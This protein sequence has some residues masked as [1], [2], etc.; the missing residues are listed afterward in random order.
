VR[1]IPAAR[2]IAVLG[3]HDLWTRHAMLERALA[4]AGA[5]LLENQCVRLASPH[6]GVS[7][8]GLDEPWTGS[9]D[10]ARAF[11]GARGAR[12][13]LVLCHSPDGLPDALDALATLP[14]A[15]RALYVCGHTHGG[16]VATPWGPVVVPG[17]VGKRYPAGSFA[18]G[19]AVLHVSRGVGGIE[20]PFRA[21]ARPEV[22]LFDLTG[23]T[24]AKT[25]DA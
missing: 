24:P 18:L 12:T 16:H 22:A 8:V 10:A 23:P 9:I 3:N 4:H 5:E 17:L 15:P 11:E 19:R 2:K 21:W 20:L 1:A 25:I 13:V 7:I 6:D 14:D